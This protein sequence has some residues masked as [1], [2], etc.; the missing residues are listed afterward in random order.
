MIIR[1]SVSSNEDEIEV[2]DDFTEDE[3]ENEVAKQIEGMIEYDWSKVE[4]EPE[5]YDDRD[6]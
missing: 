5:E 2:P 4:E 1:I 6:V 3:I